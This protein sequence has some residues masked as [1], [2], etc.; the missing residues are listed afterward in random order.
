M[1][2]SE[3]LQ[4]LLAHRRLPH[5]PL[6]KTLADPILICMSKL[7]SAKPHYVELRA[8]VVSYY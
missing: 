1:Q 4:G 8:V 3:W 2:L 5:Y 7:C 6:P